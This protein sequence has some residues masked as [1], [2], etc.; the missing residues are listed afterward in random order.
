MGGLDPR[1]LKKIIRML[2][3]QIVQSMLGKY[4]IY[5][6]ARQGMAKLVRA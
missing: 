4:G 2:D 6:G 3:S 1:M 5:L